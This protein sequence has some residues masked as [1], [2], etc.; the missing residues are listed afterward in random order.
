MISAMTK[1]LGA[2][3]LLSTIVAALA[4]AGFVVSAPLEASASPAPARAGGSAALFDMRFF[5][6][7]QAA[8]SVLGHPYRWGGSAPGGFDCSG[9]VQW[10][11]R[12]GGISLPRDSRSQRAA[13][14]PIAESELIPGDL[15]FFGSPVHH[16]GIYIGDGQMI[17]SPN[18]G[19]VVHIAPV[20]RRGME[21]SSFGRVK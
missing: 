15:V 9:L 17:H 5:P 1:H 6:V 14:F 20:H 13:T 16:V 7:M 2:R 3:R 11:F 8:G 21:P 18:S 10:S 12:Q 4:A 19:G